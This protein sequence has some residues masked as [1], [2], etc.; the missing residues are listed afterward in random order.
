MT[1]DQMLKALKAEGVKVREYKSWKTHERDAA[2]GRAFGPVNMIVVHHTAG[3]NSL[4]LCYN[5]RSD[6]PGPLCHAHLAKDG[7]L[8]LLSNGRANHA[9]SIPKNIYDSIVAERKPHPRPSG[10]EVIDAND[11]AFGL[12]IENLGNGKDVYPARQYDQAVR[13]C[14]AIC[15]FYGWSAQSVVGHKEITTRKIDPKGPVEGRGD[16]DMNRFRSDV[17]ARLDAN[18]NPGPVPPPKVEQPKKTHKV[19]K[20]DTLYSIAEDN[21]LSVGHLAHLND[22]EAPYT[23]TIGQTLALTE[24]AA[25]ATPQ[26]GPFFQSL[27]KT[28]DSTLTP[29]T[30][31]D[32]TFGTEYVDEAGTHAAS[33]TE[34][35]DAGYYHGIVNVR[36]RDLTEGR[37]FQVRLAEKQGASY[38]KTYSIHEG[39]GTA[40][41]SFSTAGF[42]GKL[43]AGRKLVVQI[44][45]FDDT[46][47]VLERVEVNAQWWH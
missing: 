23:L 37:E 45:H 20:G 22:L 16:F 41:S 43:P 27:A 30:W 11:H 2:T 3:S 39:V 42:N 35:G 9:G 12:E 31:Y 14:A 38:V 21:N 5:G 33:S 17:Q 34:F 4:S 40:G 29:A 6:L 25:T 13:Y 18:G 19:V 24:E 36:M 10:A 47:A 7:T 1:A 8:S 44:A 26:G 46:D 32:V 15:R 28:T